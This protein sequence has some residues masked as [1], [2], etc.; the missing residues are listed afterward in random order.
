MDIYFPGGVV[1]DVAMVQ[2]GGGVGADG[3]MLVIFLGMCGCS[4]FLCCPLR[5]MLSVL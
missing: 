5:G 4:E 1:V 2:E 3:S